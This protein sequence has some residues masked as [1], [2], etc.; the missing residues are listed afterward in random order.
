MAFWGKTKMTL[1]DRSQRRLITH[2]YHVDPKL[3]MWVRSKI[4]EGWTGQQI[5]SFIL[6]KILTNDQ[7]PE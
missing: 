7:I 6:A 5:Q 2:M 4:D 1:G 3:G